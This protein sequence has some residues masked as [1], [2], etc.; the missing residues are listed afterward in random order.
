MNNRVVRRGGSI[1]KH[2]GEGQVAD[3]VNLTRHL[4]RHGIVTPPASPAID[5]HMIEFPYVEGVGGLEFVLANGMQGLRELLCSIARFHEA[6]PPIGVS[7][8]DPFK[9]IRQRIPLS[10]DKRIIELAE[11]LRFSLPVNRPRC[12]LHGDLH[13]GQF[14]IDKS[15]KIWIIDLEDTALG[16]READ[17]GNFAA[18][19]ATRVETRK[20]PCL[21]DNF[22]FWLDAVLSA[23]MLDTP[24]VDGPLAMEYARIALLRRTLKLNELGEP[25]LLNQMLKRSPADFAVFS[26]G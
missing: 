10:H 22:S 7:V 12:L 14:L 4:V 26:P 6:P 2:C 5:P 11:I 3:L 9:M 13:V 25:S 20:S 8:F 21:V 15:E 1:L 19:L 23:Y 18:H 16:P 24:K 17:L